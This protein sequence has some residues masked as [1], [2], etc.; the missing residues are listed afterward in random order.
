MATVPYT[1][2]ANLAD[3]PPSPVGGWTSGA[4]IIDSLTLQPQP[5]DKW[6]ILGYSVRALLFINPQSMGPTNIRQ[7][8]KFG[9]I[10]TAIVSG[11]DYNGTTGFATFPIVVPVLPLPSDETVEADIWDPAIDPLPP[12]QLIGNPGLPITASLVL[13]TPIPLPEGSQ[14]LGIGMWMLPSLLNAGNVLTTVNFPA[15]VV[16]QAVYSVVYDDG[17]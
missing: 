9:K 17:E 14:D 10:K 12:Q 4:T 1:L 11:T 6:T 2:G 3:G 8:G 16:Q 15:L 13:A 7:F 5:R